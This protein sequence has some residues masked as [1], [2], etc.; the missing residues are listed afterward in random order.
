[1]SLF[2]YIMR[3]MGIRQVHNAL[4]ESVDSLSSA[5]PG[6]EAAASAIDGI[7]D[8]GLA[9]AASTREGSAMHQAIGHLQE[10]QELLHGLIQQAHRYSALLE[11]YHQQMSDTAPAAPGDGSRSGS[12]MPKNNGATYDTPL[13]AVQQSFLEHTHRMPLDDEAVMTMITAAVDTLG[14]QASGFM[15]ATITSLD[16]DSNEAPDNGQTENLAKLG[17]LINDQ[18]A[19][20]AA[21]WGAVSLLGMLAMTATTEQSSKPVA[22]GANNNC[23]RAARQVLEQALNE[24]L[25][26]SSDYQK[27]AEAL[28]A[29]PPVPADEVALELMLHDPLA[30]AQE[31]PAEAAS[32]GT[33]AETQ[34][35]YGSSISPP[36]EIP[37]G[38]I[39]IPEKVI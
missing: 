15:E 1:L 9:Q 20:N 21:R 31:V 27:L 25:E 39:Q 8:S 17:D 29:H 36:T 18:E 12:I 22:A 10:A 19:P 13:V 6:L 37:P 28:L 30:T 23:G 7:V 38:N 34:P 35:V 11:G 16:P 2:N 32:P 14:H 4:S 24:P 33:E 5:V 26:D 3:I